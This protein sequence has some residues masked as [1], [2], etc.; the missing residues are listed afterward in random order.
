MSLLVANPSE[1][2]PSASKSPSGID[3]ELFL[4]LAAATAAVLRNEHRIVAVSVAT[5][6]SASQP[7]LLW[8]LEGRR[9]IYSSHRLR[10]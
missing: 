8:S 5:N 2:K 6:M 9:Q 7:L 10:Y 4:V 3:P 1:S